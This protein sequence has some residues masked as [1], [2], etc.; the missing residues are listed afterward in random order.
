[1]YFVAI[2]A[3]SRVPLDFMHA[4]LA[5]WSPRP[6]FAL[7]SHTRLRS[8]AATEYGACDALGSPP[9]TCQSRI[10]AAPPPLR[11]GYRDFLSTLLKV[12]QY[13]LLEA[14]LVAREHLSAPLHVCVAIEHVCKL[15]R[16]RSHVFDRKHVFRKM[17]KRFHRDFWMY[18]AIEKSFCGSCRRPPF[19]KG[20]FKSRSV[21]PYAPRIAI[22]A[23][24]M[25]PQL[26]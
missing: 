21:L 26:I 23:D 12:A 24:L 3:D 7:W 10:C 14:T 2:E 13:R 20:R 5:K 1:M 16:P 25:I 9:L 17:R 8:R 22:Q 6:Q 11:P 15:P 4:P 18:A 19:V